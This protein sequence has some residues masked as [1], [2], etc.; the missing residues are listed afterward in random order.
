MSFL[1]QLKSQASAVQSG[2]SAQQTHNEANVKLAEAASKTVWLYITELAKL[3][4]G[5]ASSF[6]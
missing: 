6:G 3:I 5:Q 2:H 4:V 1:D